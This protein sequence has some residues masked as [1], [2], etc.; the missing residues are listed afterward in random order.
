MRERE[1]TLI[2][3]ALVA[4]GND[5][6]ISHGDLADWTLQ[7]LWDLLFLRWRSCM[8]GLRTSHSTTSYG[9]VTVVENSQTKSHL[10]S[11]RERWFTN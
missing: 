9:H 10:V 6:G 3:E 5:D 2:T 11:V 7:F 8:F 4:A 1:L